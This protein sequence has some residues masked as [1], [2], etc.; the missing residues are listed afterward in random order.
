LIAVVWKAE[1]NAKARRDV[2]K[3]LKAHKASEIKGKARS[4]A[5]AD[6]QSRA[7]WYRGAEV[8]RLSEEEAA[9]IAAR[10]VGRIEA[11]SSLTP[12][13]SAGLKRALTEII[14]ARLV[15]ENP[16]ATREPLKAAAAE[17]KVLVEFLD[18]QQ[19]EILKA[20]IEQGW[21]ALPDE[22]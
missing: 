11:R 6:F 14:R 16:D 19:F 15:E 21:R 17:R 13:K 2:T 4:K 9:I 10:L 18:D 3:Q 1:A 5:L 8:D 7:G 22:K 12:E 20:A